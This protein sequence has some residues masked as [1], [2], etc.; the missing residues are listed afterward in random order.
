MDR[1]DRRVLRECRDRSGK[2]VQKDL[3]VRRVIL[4][5]RATKDI[6]ARRV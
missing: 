2:L 1:K 6:R 5:I 4:E 3:R